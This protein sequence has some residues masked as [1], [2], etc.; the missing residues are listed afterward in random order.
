MHAKG[1]CLCQLV[2]QIGFVA[3]NESL[4]IFK[5]KNHQVQMIH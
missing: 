4:D 5:T 1:A 3:F 2:H